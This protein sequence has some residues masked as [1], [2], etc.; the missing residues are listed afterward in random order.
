LLI[1]ISY[2]L[3]QNIPL[4]PG[5]HDVEFKRV[6]SIE[7]N[8]SANVS[9][10]VFSNHSGTHIDAPLHFCNKGYSVADVL[11]I[12]NDYFPAVCIDIPKDPGS[13]ICKEDIDLFLKKIVDAEAILIRSGFFEYRNEEPSIYSTS[14]PW[15]HPEVPIYL[16]QNCPKL[17][18]IGLDIISISN[19]SHR[20]E[21]HTAH[22]S[23]LCH[24]SP[25]LLLEDADLSNSALLDTEFV[26]HIY[27]WVI[28]EVDATPVV[29]MAEFK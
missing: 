14:H 18:I 5:S 6:R 16:R 8:E 22:R 28:D 26:L 10:F 7:N 27:P 9:V 24:D 25:I 2:A 3:N 20:K 15:V 4:Y 21:G 13:Q 11:A 23:F 19:P 17:K 12:K 1:P 29:A